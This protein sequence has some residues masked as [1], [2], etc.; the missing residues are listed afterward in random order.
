MP[1]KFTPGE[2][3]PIIVAATEAAA[4]LTSGEETTFILG[5]R[6][7]LLPIGN[8]GIPLGIPFDPALCVNGEIFAEACQAFTGLPN[9]AYDWMRNNT[10]LDIF[11][12]AVKQQD[13]MK[14]PMH[15]VGEIEDSWKAWES[16]NSLDARMAINQPK[17]TLLWKLLSDN[18]MQCGSKVMTDKLKAWLLKGLTVCKQSSAALGEFHREHICNSNYLPAV[19]HPT[20]HGWQK[21]YLF[22]AI[23]QEL[24]EELKVFNSVP[25]AH[26]ESEASLA[27]L[28]ITIKGT[29]AAESPPKHNQANNGEEAVPNNYLKWYFDAEDQPEKKT[30]L[31]RLTASGR[32]RPPSSS[33]PLAKKLFAEQPVK[34]KDDSSIEEVSPPPDKKHKHELRRYKEKEEDNELGQPTVPTTRFLVPYEQPSTAMGR[35]YI[36]LLERLTN[37]PST[38][39]SFTVPIPLDDDEE[40][41]NLSQYFKQRMGDAARLLAHFGAH[42]FHP[43][44]RLGP[45]KSDAEGSIFKDYQY[46]QPGIVSVD[47]D[48]NVLQ[49]GKTEDHKIRAYFIRCIKAATSLKGSFQ[50]SKPAF[51]GAE[52]YTNPRCVQALRSGI[53]ETGENFENKKEIVEAALTPL[54]FILSVQEGFKLPASGWKC[55]TCLDWLQNQI[56]F[57]NQVFLAGDRYPSLESVHVNISPCLLCGPLVGQYAFA[58]DLLSQ[59]DIETIW[60]KLEPSARLK[61]TTALLIAIRDLW[62]IILDWSNTPYRKRHG[63]QATFLLDMSRSDLVVFK[64]FVTLRA[65]KLDEL[66]EVWRQQFTV[67]FSLETLNAPNLPNT[68]FYN[69]KVPTDILP[70]RQKQ[71][72]RQSDGRTMATTTQGKSK[73]AVHTC[74]RWIPRIEKVSIKSLLDAVPTKPQV[75]GKLVCFAFCLQQAGGCAY[76]PC[77]RLHIDLA[78]NP[79]SWTRDRLRELTAFFNHPFIR[80]KLETSGWY[81]N[82]VGAPRAAN[83]APPANQPYQPNP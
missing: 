20:I 3:F 28:H 64:S 77:D 6:A 79:A 8:H 30:P 67:T 32:K 51:T 50:I 45:T 73:K 70:E 41:F 42:I 36:S 60:E 46:L 76:N 68:G 23:I 14:V 75:D 57:F 33:K 49:S 35:P 69:I 65:K 10:L 27:L 56:F 71:Q 52:F 61:T 9:E 72:S 19:C 63:H 48:A 25:V 37:K 78:E 13:Q 83:N 43:Y 34:E 66:L 24:P 53:F 11:L 12:G 26:D 59:R 15:F 2:K 38:T 62:Q 58:M 31:S 74:A 80:T 29:D 82:A 55:R 47:Y 22:Q 5:S 40:D 17:S 16:K 4:S 44:M 39:T 21:K 7:F 54:H 1:P 81:N 18:W